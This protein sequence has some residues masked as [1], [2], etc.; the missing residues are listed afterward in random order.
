VAEPIANSREPITSSHEPSANSSEYLTGNPESVANSREP[1]TSSLEPLINSHELPLKSPELAA[2]SREPLITNA[3][4]TPPVQQALPMEAAATD[5]HSESDSS[6]PIATT[7]NHNTTSDTEQITEMSAD[8]PLAASSP[9]KTQPARPTLAKATGENPF[10][11]QH[12]R[13]RLHGNNPPPLFDFML[14]NSNNPAPA[15]ISSA[16]SSDKKSLHQDL[17]KDVVDALMPQLEDELRQRLKELTQEELERLRDQ[18][19]A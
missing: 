2:K 10:L 4:S 16:G 13:A 5:I 19:Q 3:A 9:T 8:E 18:P 7:T 15:T 11:P 12:I 1:I 14:N 17:I 6:H